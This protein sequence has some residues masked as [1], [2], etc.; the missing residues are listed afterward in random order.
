MFTVPCPGGGSVTFPGSRVPG[1]AQ[2]AAACRSQNP[3]G[4]VGITINPNR[5]FT[6][7]DPT[8]GGFPDPGFPLP[9]GG[10]TQGGGFLG[11]LIQQCAQWLPISLCRSAAARGEQALLDLIAGGN[12]GQDTTAKGDGCPS[13]YIEVDGDCLRSG[14]Q[15]TAERTLPGGATGTLD[16]RAGDAVIGAFGQPALT[17]RVVGQR[18]RKDGSMSTILDCIVPGMV[19]GKD[20][21]CY[22]KSCIPKK[23]RKWPPARKP[24]VTAADAKAIRQASS[25][26]NRVKRLAGKVG[27]KCTNTKSGL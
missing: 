17:P 18:E 15:G 20:N 10:T 3:S 5:G 16:D 7:L 19:L 11:P 25:A 13:G 24:P 23:F 21:L 9:G 26:K 22:E 8:S 4:A 14:M 27:F 2:I 1:Q 12:T 6:P